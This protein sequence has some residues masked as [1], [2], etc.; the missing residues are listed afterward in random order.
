MSFATRPHG[1]RSFGYATVF[2]AA[3]ALG[4]ALCTTTPAAAQTGV[5]PDAGERKG[6][7]HRIE[8]RWHKLLERFDANGDGRL[9]FEELGE[10]FQRASRLDTNGDGVLDRTDLEARRGQRQER[11]AKFRSELEG[12]SKEERKAKIQEARKQ[13]ATARFAR[14]DKNQ[15]GV[16]DANEAPRLVQRADKNGDGVVT[17]EELRAGKKARLQE[18][19]GERKERRKARGGKKQLS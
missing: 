8:K 2:V 10:R 19:R 13:K 11:R 12:L 16:I 15:D 14:K 3:C 4:V 7:Q 6:K 18:R 5:A 9:A 1:T 17:R